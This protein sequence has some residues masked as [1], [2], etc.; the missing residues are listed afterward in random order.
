MLAEEAME[1]HVVKLAEGASE[2]Y[3]PKAPSAKGRCFGPHFG[4]SLPRTPRR[5][6]RPGRPWRRPPAQVWGEMEQRFFKKPRRIGGSEA[7]QVP[8]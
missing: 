2:L 6:C 5:P 3:V 8:G 7:G 1:S 4:R